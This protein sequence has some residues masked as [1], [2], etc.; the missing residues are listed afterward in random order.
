MQWLKSAGVIFMG[1]AAIAVLI[2]I[3]VAIFSGLGW[4]FDRVYPWILRGEGLLLAFSVASLPLAFFA[5]TRAL[6]ALALRI[7]SNFFWFGLWVLGFLIV[8]HLWGVGWLIGGLGLG[9]VGVV[10]LAAI[11]A[12][13]S[14]AWSLL[15]ALVGNFVVAL[16]STFA[17]I[18]LSEMHERQV[19]SA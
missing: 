16:G 6:P 9:I 19:L 4:L 11:A 7:S 14:G 15:G 10:P 8:Y 1:L 2:F 18:W 17:G 3:T 12:L 13:L 5:R